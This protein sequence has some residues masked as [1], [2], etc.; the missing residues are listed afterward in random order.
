MP[1]IAESLPDDIRTHEGRVPERP[2]KARAARTAPRLADIVKAVERL[3]ARVDDLERDAAQA[4][5]RERRG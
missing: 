2:H 1:T 5:E 4:R 3:A